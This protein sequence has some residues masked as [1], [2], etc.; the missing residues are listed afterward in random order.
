MKEKY[1]VIPI[2]WRPP[3]QKLNEFIGRYQER[4]SAMAQ[5]Y[6]MY[7]VLNAGCHE[8]GRAY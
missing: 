2:L 1:I 3:Q 7:L 4:E 8:K 5:L 6:H